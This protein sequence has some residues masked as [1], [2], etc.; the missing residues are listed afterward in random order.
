MMVGQNLDCQR[1]ENRQV[2]II[3]YPLTSFGIAQIGQNPKFLL[4]LHYEKRPLDLAIK[5]ALKISSKSCNH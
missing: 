4:T 3:V 5:V 2:K 1:R